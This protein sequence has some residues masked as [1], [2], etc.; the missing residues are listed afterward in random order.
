M[1]RMSNIDRA[2]FAQSEPKSDSASG[3]LMVLLGMAV[4]IAIAMLFAPQSG[5]EV[6]SAVMLRMGS[7]RRRGGK[8]LRGVRGKVMP[9]RAAERDA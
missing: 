1:E 4:G 5:E 6:R 9:I 8:M 3:L 2:G 7:A